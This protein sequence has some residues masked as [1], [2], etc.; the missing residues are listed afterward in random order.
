[1][2]KLVI[3]GLSFPTR[4]RKHALSL[5]QN[6]LIECTSNISN[7]QEK[8]MIFSPTPAPNMIYS[9]IP[10]MIISYQIQEDHHPSLKKGNGRMLWMR[11]TPGT[12]RSL[13]PRPRM[14]SVQSRRWSHG[15]P[16]TRA[17]ASSTIMCITSP[18]SSI[19]MA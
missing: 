6:L 19:R 9:I 11:R 18:V 2:L 5:N 17:T 12:A 3:H 4:D 13:R 8:T 10:Q 15:G 16:S 14:R 1:M 7:C